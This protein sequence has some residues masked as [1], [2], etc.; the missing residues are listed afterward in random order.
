MGYQLYCVILCVTGG[1]AGVRPNCQRLDPSVSGRACGGLGFHGVHR[2]EPLNAGQLRAVPTVPLRV[3]VAAVVPTPVVARSTGSCSNR[4]A[5]GL[6]GF[7]IPPAGR[8]APLAVGAV[9]SRANP[10]SSHSLVTG[11]QLP[12]ASLYS[13]RSQPSI[14][15]Q[16]AVACVRGRLAAEP[17]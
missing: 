3:S 5:F 17:L 8:P 13:T 1:A 6:I 16:L 15:F 10:S 11:F 2:P 4:I 12:F 7:T 14:R 9:V